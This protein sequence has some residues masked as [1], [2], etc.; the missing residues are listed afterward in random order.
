[1]KYIVSHPALTVAIPAT[2]R[3]DHL[4]ENMAAATGPMPD[5]SQRRQMALAFDN[6]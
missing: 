6:L 3:V 4:R 5:V 1:L 2:R